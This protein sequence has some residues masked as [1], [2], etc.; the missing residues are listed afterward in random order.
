MQAQVTFVF[1]A[2]LMLSLA[3]IVR[4]ECHRRRK[5]PDLKLGHLDQLTRPRLTYTPPPERP[6]RYSLDQ[7]R[8]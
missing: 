3:Q 7:G 4:W 2:V 1:W 6:R 8:P 5:G